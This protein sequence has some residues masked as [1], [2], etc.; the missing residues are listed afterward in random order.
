MGLKKLF[1]DLEKLTEHLKSCKDSCSYFYHSDNNGVIRAWEIATHALVCRRCEDENCVR[2]C[3]T[4]A[5]EKTDDKILV[6]HNMLCIS[7]KSCVQACH[8]GTLYPEIRTYLMPACDYCIDNVELSG[9][10]ECVKKCKCGA[11]KFGGFKEDKEKDIYAISNNLIV[12][13]VQW[14]RDGVKKK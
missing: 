4:N 2:A 12:H 3:P 8:S 1:I 13:S 9:E 10:P 7:C 14:E 5:L 6:R 11:I